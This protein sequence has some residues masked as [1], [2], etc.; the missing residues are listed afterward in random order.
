[1]SLFVP[2][3]S[4]SPANRR[5]RSSLLRQTSESS[6]LLAKS[7][8]FSPETVSIMRAESESSGNHRLP[9]LVSRGGGGGG[10]TLAEM[11]GD[12]VPHLAGRSSPQ[13]E[14]RYYSSQHSS[15]ARA[16]SSVQRYRSR[17]DKQSAERVMYFADNPH[18]IWHSA[19]R[20]RADRAILE[21][22]LEFGEISQ[23]LD[24]LLASCYRLPPRLIGAVAYQPVVMGLNGIK[25]GSTRSQAIY[26][27]AGY[28]PPMG[29]D[30]AAMAPTG[31]LQAGP[32]L[33]DA[34]V[35]TDFN[36]NDPA[37]KVSD[38]VNSGSGG[39]TGSNQAVLLAKQAAQLPAARLRKIRP[40]TFQLPLNNHAYLSM[41]CS[42]LVDIRADPILLLCAG[43][44][45]LPSHLD[46]LIQRT[47][48]SER[49]GGAGGSYPGSALTADA[50][51]HYSA[52]QVAH[53]L[54]NL[55]NLDRSSST[56]AGSTGNPSPTPHS[57]GGPTPDPSG[58]SAAQLP[59]PPPPQ[60]PKPFPKRPTVIP[61][62]L[63]SNVTA[64]SSH[65]YFFQ[66]TTPSVLT[67]SSTITRQAQYAAIGGAHELVPSPMTLPSH[68]IAAINPWG[69]SDT[70]YSASP[71]VL[72]FPETAEM[73]AIWRMEG[74]PYS[75]ELGV[76]LGQIQP[77][78]SRSRAQSQLMPS[79]IAEQLGLS[80]WWGGAPT[81][82]SRRNPAAV[83]TNMAD[84]AAHR[85]GDGADLGAAAGGHA[86]S[87]GGAGGA[88]ASG[89]ASTN[90]AGAGVGVGGTPQ[91]AGTGGA[92]STDPADPW[93]GATPEQLK[94][95]AFLASLPHPGNN[96]GYP[97]HCVVSFY[98]QNTPPL[99]PKYDID[100]SI[101]RRHPQ[102]KT[103]RLQRVRDHLRAKMEEANGP[104]VGGT[105][106][107]GTGVGAGGGV[108]MGMGGMG[109]PG[110]SHSMSLAATNGGLA[111]HTGA[112]PTASAAALNVS[113]VAGQYHRSMA[114]PTG[115]GYHP[116]TII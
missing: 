78:P 16:N 18:Y 70:L 52:S 75:L 97:Q 29:G 116:T 41:R 56:T 25:L 15:P 27:L 95:L 48:T 101:R 44:Q 35:E 111:S 106:A 73:Q 22:E 115:L 12:A 90:G 31:L 42:S 113:K 99:Y 47:Q 72:I 59:P 71:C 9:R 91:A 114:I 67:V 28:Y 104:T 57:S 88:P 58:L 39:G 69:N 82:H 94:R 24:P 46:E 60:A 6:S 64:W 13:G 26:N 68:Q 87:L 51:R 14:S 79:T 54:G 77:P 61:A 19:N 102:L 112:Y 2:S 107:V 5:A 108:G 74:K 37:H 86:R 40:L 34:V 85:R 33:V 11:A 50:L 109:Y 84:A 4:T 98:T 20:T 76:G 63:A 83:T 93:A 55:S 103:R 92:G 36:S 8:H 49:W 23:F 21:S 53:V 1:M 43:D 100:P 3:N 80:R 30:T 66:D 7:V 17:S 32:G 65:Q 110:G 38:F 62:Y 45:P 81:S 10:L 89:S 105:G 96:Q